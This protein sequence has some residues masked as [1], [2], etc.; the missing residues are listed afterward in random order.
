VRAEN[1]GGIFRDFREFFDEHR[2]AFAQAID[3][4][5]VMNHFMADIDGGAEDFDGAFNDFDRTIDAG[6]ETA[7]IGKQ[8]I[9]RGELFL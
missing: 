6:T 5:A 1:H 4:I 9:H 3:H 8:D 2:A 7:G